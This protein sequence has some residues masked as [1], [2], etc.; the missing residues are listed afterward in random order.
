MI[1]IKVSLVSN[2]VWIKKFDGQEKVIMTDD[3]IK[4]WDIIAEY[5]KYAD[6]VGIVPK[7][8]IYAK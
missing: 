1:E 5:C 3:K 7:I 6:M 8:D 2:K 4:Y